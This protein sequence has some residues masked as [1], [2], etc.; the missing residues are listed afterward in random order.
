MNIAKTIPV[1]IIF[2]VVLLTPI[3]TYADWAEEPFT[4]YVDWTAKPS[5]LLDEWVNRPLEELNDVWGMT[6]LPFL[7]I[8]GFGPPRGNISVIN[9]ACKIRFVFKE[10]RVTGWH[11]DN[12]KKSCNQVI[13]KHRRPRVLQGTPLPWE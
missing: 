8:P 9:S 13:T 1:K 12:W 7:A 10:G 2:A 11:V 3:N 5:M 6:P 4:A